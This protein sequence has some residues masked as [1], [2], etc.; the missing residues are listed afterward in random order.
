MFFK[1]FGSKNPCRL[2]VAGVHGNEEAT[3]KPLLKLLARD[4][5]NIIGR[6]ILVS[7][8]SAD[9]YISTLD[10]AYYDSTNGRKLLD[11]V[12][13][14]KPTIYLELH[15]YEIKN[16]AKL[17]DPDRKSKIGVPPFTELE[18]HILI[19][20][21]SPLIRTTEFKRED[22]CFTLELP[23]PLSEKALQ[24]AMDILRI[25]AICSGRNEI[26]GKLR[27]KYPEQIR[28]AERNFIEF[29]K[30]TMDVSFF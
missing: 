8:S 14:Y 25:I 2:F 30:E 1:E 7:L 13:Q 20:S 5:E 6:L 19:G 22:L 17:T 24:V 16:H 26:I 10:K 29:F 27:I 4:I 18:Q 11:L 12:H 15:S 9:P 3:T 23:V 21:V 28:E